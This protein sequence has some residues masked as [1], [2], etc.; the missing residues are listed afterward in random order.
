[1]WKNCK[2]PIDLVEIMVKRYF[3]EL[4]VIQGNILWCPFGFMCIS[5][6][7]GDILVGVSRCE[8]CFY[9]QV[10]SFSNNVDACIDV[11]MELFIRTCFVIHFFHSDN[12]AYMVRSSG[13]LVIE[14]NFIHGN[15]LGFT[16]IGFLAAKTLDFL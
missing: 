6:Y 11:S 9:T 7:C 1:M 10:I 13:L 4:L 2:K 3:E 8:Y 5:Q 12:I 15:I 14:C 16:Y